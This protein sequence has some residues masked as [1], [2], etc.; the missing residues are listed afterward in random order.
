VHPAYKWFAVSEDKKASNLVDAFMYARENWTPW[1]G[2]MTVWTLPDPTWNAD[3]EEYWW[4]ITN[5]DG[6]ARKA[7][8][9]IRQDRMSGVLP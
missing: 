8:E 4:A 3:R 2:V 7:Y 9:L 5:P 1:I 6:T